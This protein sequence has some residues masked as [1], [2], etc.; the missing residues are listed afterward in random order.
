[1]NKYFFALLLF[2]FQFSFSQ[3]TDH[4]NAVLKQ[5]KIKKSEINQQLYTEKVLPYDTNKSVLVIPKYASEVS[6]DYFVADAYILV[7]DNSTGK[8]LY[9]FIEPNAWTSDAIKLRYISI[10]TGLYLLNKTTRA[11]G[12]RANYQNDSQLNPYEETKLSLY[13]VN[14][15]SLKHILKN[16]ILLQSNG[17]WDRTCTGE[18]EKETSTIDMDKV[19][20]NNFNNII[21]KTKTVKTKNTL[22]KG[23]CIAKETIK[24][25]TSKLIFNGK[26]YK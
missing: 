3:D 17:D 11:F 2:S 14:K 21:V 6:D 7:I 8:I 26:E 16:Y 13:I 4:L 12:V 5:L 23:D 25:E 9:K 19:Q 10:D 20:T 1:M 22:K 18:F 15:N 24:K